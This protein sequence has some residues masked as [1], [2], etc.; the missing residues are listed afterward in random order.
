ML[1]SNIVPVQAKVLNESQSRGICDVNIRSFPTGE[2]V[3]NASDYEICVEEIYAP[4]NSSYTPIDLNEKG[5]TVVV[6]CDVKTPPD[7]AIPGLVY[8][9]NFFH[10]I[11]LVFQLTHC[12]PHGK[13]DTVQFF[14][15]LTTVN[16]SWDHITCGVNDTI[17]PVDNHHRLSNNQSFWP[18][19]RS[20]DTLNVWLS[21]KIPLL[22]CPYMDSAIVMI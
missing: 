10:S 15:K 8:G 19:N 7:P 13:R 21:I 17:C 12:Q 18:P 2:I 4:V 3:D 16:Q 6:L 5:Y 9:A 22:S 14:Q 1:T 11:F 20:S